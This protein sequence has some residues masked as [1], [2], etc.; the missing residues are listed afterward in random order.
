MRYAYLLALIIFVFILKACSNSVSTNSDIEKGVDSKHTDND[1][2]ISSG[3]TENEEIAE[4]TY[5]E[6]K[7][8]RQTWM[9]KNLNVTIMSNGTPIRQAKNVNEWKKAFDKKEPVWCFKGFKES[10]EVFYNWFA[11]KSNTLAPKG[12]RLPITKDWTDLASIL[13]SK[14]SKIQKMSD[15][16]YEEITEISSSVARALVSNQGWMDADKSFNSSKFSALPVGYFSPSEGFMYSEGGAGTAFWTFDGAKVWIGY[17]GGFSF[18]ID[19]ESYIKQWNEG[20]SVRCIK[21]N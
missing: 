11:V 20:Y 4:V 5:E 8:G 17:D 2:I 19:A 21:V 3:I 18:S 16:Q 10:G 6:V 9:L 1:T 12:Y 13:N 15:E 14:Y 7:I